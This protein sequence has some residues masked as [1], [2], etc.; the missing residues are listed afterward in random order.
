M[1]SET[2]P[3]ACYILSDES[4]IH[5]YSTSNGYYARGGCLITKVCVLISV[6]FS[7]IVLGLFDPPSKNRDLSKLQTAISQVRVSYRS[8]SADTRSIVELEVRGESTTII[9]R[10]QH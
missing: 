4:S 9:N 5:S 10:W 6:C 3:S 1:G 7:S 2:L 8:A